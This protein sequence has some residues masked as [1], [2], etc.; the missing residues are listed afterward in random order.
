MFDPVSVVGFVGTT[1]GLISFMLTTVEKL[2]DKK[3]EWQECKHLLSWYKSQYDATLL[4]LKCWKN[5][6]C[7][8][9]HPWHDPAYLYFWGCDGFR[10]VKDRV[11]GI[12]IEDEK[13]RRLI[14]CVGNNPKSAPSD[15]ESPHEQNNLVE[16]QACLQGLVAHPISQPRPE[17]WMLRF[18]LALYKHADIKT[19][20]TRL[21]ERVGD[22]DTFSKLTFWELQEQQDKSKQV[23][24]DD[25]GRLYRVRTAVERLE[26]FLKALGEDSPSHNQW[27]LILGR[28]EISE[29]LIT[30]A[31]DSVLTLEFL[32]EQTPLKDRI[33]ARVYIDCPLA[34]TELGDMSDLERMIK[35][36]AGATQPVIQA[37][38][39]FLEQAM[40][41][42][43]LRK[44][45]EV[46]R[47]KVA[48][49]LV[50][51]LIICYGTPCTSD[52]CTCGVRAT[53]LMNEGKLWSFRA[54]DGNHNCH[55][56]SLRNRGFVLLAVALAELALSKP[57]NVVQSTPGELEFHVVSP[58]GFKSF[59]LAGLLKLIS[60]RTCRPYRKAVEYCFEMD[61]KL[62]RREIRPED[63][64][65]CMEKISQP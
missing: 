1:A 15:P 16:W 63:F 23:L 14:F 39:E 43:D 32:V 19:R 42:D 53:H 33:V 11:D 8:E 28:P 10:A 20:I 25:I 51:S 60:H 31:E 18:C 21:K 45:G 61:R 49:G 55:D 2:H 54:F 65:R 17:H 12:L 24:S 58:G 36:P 9:G 46:V 52:L 40:I 50:D 5:I 7:P 13:I 34:D 29:G 64:T 3:S 27:S 30:L 59:G 26:R 44:A 6:W 56:Q 48:S 35:H 4:Q 62:L 57:I 41:K 37:M 38:K 47:T 22:L